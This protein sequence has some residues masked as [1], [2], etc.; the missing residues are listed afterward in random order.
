MA[1]WN[2]GCILLQ[3]LVGSHR[4]SNREV[5]N[6]FKGKAF[7][8]EAIGIK[9]DR[10][11]KFSNTTK[12]LLAGLLHHN[13]T[14]R[15]KLADLF[16]DKNASEAVAKHAAENKQ[17]IPPSKISVGRS[18]R[19]SKINAESRVVLKDIAQSLAQR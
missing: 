4:L 8:F 5:I 11:A 14:K 12:E 1:V 6:K 19:G 10:I 16:K 3:L 17:A 9:S 7:S 18:V 13:P 2:L 15:T